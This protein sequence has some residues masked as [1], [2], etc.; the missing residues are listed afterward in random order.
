M[1]IG[2]LYR[3]SETDT[4]IPKQKRIIIVPKI[5]EKAL[6]GHPL[7]CKKH[8]MLYCPVCRK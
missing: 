8:N 5:W 1:K 6:K 7:Y 2:G 4:N 3:Y